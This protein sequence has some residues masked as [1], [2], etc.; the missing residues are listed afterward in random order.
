MAIPLQLALTILSLISGWVASKLGNKSHSTED[1]KVPK[2]LSFFRDISV[3][4][5]IVMFFVDLVVGTIAPTLVPKGSTL[6]TVSLNAGLMFGGGL[7][8]LLYGVSYKCSQETNNYSIR[9]VIK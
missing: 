9:L 7:L 5:G 4:G 1:I 6:F 2:S 8:V 3:S